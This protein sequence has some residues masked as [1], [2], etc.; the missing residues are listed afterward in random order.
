MGA[1]NGGKRAKPGRLHFE[2]PGLRTHE[3]I[4]TPNPQGRNQLA[5]IL[6]LKMKI[7]LHYAL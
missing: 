5:S 4:I 2:A 7:L 6:G 1:I 3:T